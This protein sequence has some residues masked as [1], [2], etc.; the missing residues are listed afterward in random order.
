MPRGAPGAMSSEFDLAH[1]LRPFARAGLLSF[2]LF[3]LSASFAY[4][5]LRSTSPAALRVPLEIYTAVYLAFWIAAIVAMYLRRPSPE[6]AATLWDR[7]AKAIIYG[8]HIAC[9]WLIWAI[10][11][12]GAVET[13][14]MVVVF[15]T[16]YAPTQI[17]SSPENTLAN[18]VG[19]VAVVGST[20]VFLATRGSSVAILLS[21]Y[22]AFYG[23][24]MFVLSDAVRSTVRLTVDARLASEKAA[25]ELERLL[26]VVTS[27][28]D[29]KT[30]FISSAS[31]DLGQPL[32]AVALFFDQ[33]RRAPDEASRA[34]AAEGVLRALASADQLLAHMLNHLRLEADAVEPQLSR[35]ALRPLLT[36]TAALH[37]PL[38]Q[39][40]G[41]AIRTRSGD[42]ALM[43]DPVLVERALG[44]L[45][46]NAIQHSGGSR[47]LLAVRR[48]G[49]AVRIWAIDD[50]AGVGRADAKHIFEDYYQ[51]PA[52]RG[53]VRTGFG[54]GLPSV[55]RIAE[56][57]GGTA[58]LDPRWTKGAAFYLEFPG[59]KTAIAAPTRRFTTRFSRIP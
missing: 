7:I 22:L 5:T 43:L 53:G 28:R 40:A 32:Q 20:S 44:N 15:L 52:P 1:P 39:A 3:S 57:M 17:I 34:R 14:L 10:L 8:A 45:V 36:R 48:R 38:A 58:G 35:V 13:Q 9:V 46:H 16:A 4:F 25:A 11:P 19:I 55:K 21:I 6:E 50:G 2:G 42:L 51:G 31:H 33:T 29:A 54:L 41:V 24:M 26:A 59:A 18:R 23:A 12:Y 30:R 47:L 56:L 37:L 49:E 27:E